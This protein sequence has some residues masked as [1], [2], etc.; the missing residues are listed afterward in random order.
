MSKS[1]TGIKEADK[2]SG[3]MQ[4]LGH[5][6]RREILQCIREGDG[7]CCE[8]AGGRFG[9]SQP[10]LSGHLR[11]LREAGFI[12]F[13][14]EGNR[15]CWTMISGTWLSMF[16]QLEQIT[17]GIQPVAAILGASKEVFLAGVSSRKDKYGSRIGRLLLK[18]GFHL[19]PIH[20]HLEEWEGLPTLSSIS[21]ETAGASLV[22]VTPPV[23]SARLTREAWEK[24]IR[25]F[26]FQPGT[27]D[28]GVIGE[29]V[30]QGAQ[31]VAGGPCLLKR[32]LEVEE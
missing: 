21:P 28:P 7:I 1:E 17:G 12:E 11:V 22:L 8:D 19:K 26:W 18:A 24:G 13:R 23:I 6:L 32:L 2:L 4:A 15:R 20:P 5:P 14:K 29:V 27:E 31:V 10:T 16:D 25:R 30:S 9:V 3:C